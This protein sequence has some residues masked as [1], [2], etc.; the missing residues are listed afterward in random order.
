MPEPVLATKEESQELVLENR[1]LREEV[2]RLS[3]ELKKS[4]REIR[5]S[6]S[7]LDKVTKAAKAKD[8]LNE[9]L[10]DANLRQRAYTDMLLQSCPN[11]IILF[12]N[13]GRFVLSTEVFMTVTS[14][15]NFDYIKNRKFAEV[16]PKYFSAE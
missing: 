16:F 1:V 11:I 12:D 9:A 10:S 5:I 8:A 15:P 14:T 2:E 3:R 4:A 7:F 13:D 6:N